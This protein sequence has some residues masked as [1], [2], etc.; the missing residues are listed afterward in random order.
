MTL[1]SHYNQIH[2]QSPRIPLASPVRWL[3][4]AL[5]IAIIGVLLM[6]ALQ[7]AGQ[8]ADERRRRHFA[9]P[10]SSIGATGH[11]PPH[12]Q[13][14]SRSLPQ[15][16]SPLSPSSRVAFEAASGHAS[17]CGPGGQHEETVQE[18]C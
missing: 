6:Y 10:L 13:A 7:V 5:F 3:P 17:P 2:L 11:L 16:G 14:L 8:A 4:L 12:L 1:C 9:E 18:A 15:C